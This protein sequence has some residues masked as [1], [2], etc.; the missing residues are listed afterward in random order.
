VLVDQKA[1]EYE[2]EVSFDYFG[3]CGRLLKTNKVLFF[4]TPYLEAL[5]NTWANGIGLEHPE[6]SQTHESFISSLLSIVRTDLS[7]V[8]DLE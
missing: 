4:S 1:F 8:A 5:L 2:P 6:A 3:M 7:Q